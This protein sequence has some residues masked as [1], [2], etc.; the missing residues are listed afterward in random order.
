[1]ETQRV[2]NHSTW[3]FANEIMQS[4]QHLERACSNQRIWTRTQIFLYSFTGYKMALL[5]LKL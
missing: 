5:I 4:S 3:D 1:M 2:F